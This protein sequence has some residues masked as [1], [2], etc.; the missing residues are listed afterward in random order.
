MTKAELIAALANVADGDE[1]LICSW[2]EGVRVGPGPGDLFT[3]RNV[4]YHSADDNG[5]DCAP[6]VVIDADVEFA[7]TFEE[8]K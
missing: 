7:E 5:P 2:P 1:V 8:T 6:F 4:T 3:V